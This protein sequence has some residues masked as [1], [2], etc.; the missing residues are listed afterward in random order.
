MYFYP[1]HSGLD[2]SASCEKLLAPTAWDMICFCLNENNNS[3]SER[4]EW[5]FH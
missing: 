5:K 1:D 2:E 3:G 4:G